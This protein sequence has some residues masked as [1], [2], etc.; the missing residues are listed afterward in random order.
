MGES[1]QAGPRCGA[2]RAGSG[3]VGAWRNSVLMVVAFT[4]FA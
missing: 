2:H 3:Q 4:E 1:G